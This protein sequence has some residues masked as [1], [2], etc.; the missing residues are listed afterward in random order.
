MV[1]LGHIYDDKRILISESQG[2]CAT[3]TTSLAGDHMGIFF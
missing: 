2:L 1:L 3:H